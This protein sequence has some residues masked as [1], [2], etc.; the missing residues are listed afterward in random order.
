MF[1]KKTYLLCISLLLLSVLFITTGCYSLKE[2]PRKDIALTG[3]TIYVIHTADTS[4]ILTGSDCS[5]GFIKGTI[6]PD[7]SRTP[8]LRTVHF[9][10]APG[11]AVQQDGKMISVPV[12]NIAKVETARTDGIKIIGFLTTAGFVGIPLIYLISL[13]IT[14]GYD[15]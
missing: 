2:I 8:R 10:I 1:R 12:S 14:G 4:Y 3:R 9:Y 6:D 13:I 15:M 11:S 7:N 5:G